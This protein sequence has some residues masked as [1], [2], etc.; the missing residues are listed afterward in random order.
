MCP[1]CFEMS[2]ELGI[3]SCSLSRVMVIAFNFAFLTKCF[4]VLVFGSKGALD[5][6]GALASF[7]LFD[8]ASLSHSFG[9][10]R[11]A[12]NV[13]LPGGQCFFKWSFCEFSLSMMLF[14]SSLVIDQFWNFVFLHSL[15]NNVIETT[16]DL[17]C[18]SC[19]AFFL[20]KD[21]WLGFTESIG[22]N[23]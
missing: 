21:C 17:C 7:S 8:Y 22:L 9:W 13:M 20:I 6:M 2:R 18:I 1:E 19:F 14:V 5:S 16:H 3:V 23:F 12:I 15:A 10:L 11:I 4:H